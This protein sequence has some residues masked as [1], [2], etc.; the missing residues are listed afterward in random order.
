M[1]QPDAA[2]VSAGDVRAGKDGRHR[3]RRRCDG[4]GGLSKREIM[5][6]L[7]TQLTVGPEIAGRA[8][9]LGRSASYRA[10]DPESGSIQS[11][12]KGG[13]IVVPTAPIRRI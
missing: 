3:Q 8:Y 6:L 2:V 7:Q 12:R 9:G 1:T 4:A 10:C 5:R 13:K 11:F